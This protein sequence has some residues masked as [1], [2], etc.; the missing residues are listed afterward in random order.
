MFKDSKEIL[1]EE[2]ENKKPKA[3][4]A[5]IDAQLAKLG[6]D[7]KQGFLSNYEKHLSVTHTHH[8]K[9]LRDAH[10]LLATSGLTRAQQEKKLINLLKGFILT[11]LPKVQT[12]AENF[13]SGCH[14]S[15]K[16][17]RQSQPVKLSR[18]LSQQDLLLTG[19]DDEMEIA[20]KKQFVRKRSLGLG[21]KLSIPLR[22][23]VSYHFANEAVLRLESFQ[24]KFSQVCSEFLESWIHEMLKVLDANKKASESIDSLSLLVEEQEKYLKKYLSLSA[25]FLENLLKEDVSK[26]SVNKIDSQ[27]KSEAPRLKS[28]E[29]HA[30]AHSE[31]WKQK[32]GLLGGKSLLGLHLDALKKNLEAEIDSIVKQTNDQLFSAEEKELEKAHELLT[33]LESLFQHGMYLEASQLSIGLSINVRYDELQL[34]ESFLKFKEISRKPPSLIR[35]L[36]SEHQ[37]VPL[38]A[39]YLCDY[40]VET[41]LS[42]PLQNVL[43]QFPSR[44]SSALLPV[45]TALQKIGGKVS[46]EQQDVL[47]AEALDNL[48]KNAKSALLASSEELQA[49]KVQF[50][51]KVQD[52]IN[53]LEEKLEVD[54]LIGEAE[55]IS[56]ADENE[57]QKSGFSRFFKNWKLF[58]A[59]L[60]Y[61]LKNQISRRKEELQYAEFKAQ[62]AKDESLHSK[63]RNLFEAVSPNQKALD[64]L[65]FYYQ[66]LFVGKHAPREGLYKNREREM[67][68]AQVALSRIE[69][70][71]GGA[72]LAIGEAYSGTSFFCDM[73]LRKMGDKNI[74]R[75][76]APPGGSTKRENLFRILG[77][78]LSH[79]VAGIEII[80]QAPTGSVFLFN[81][82][83]LWWARHENGWEVIDTICEIIEHYSREYTFIMN[84]NSQAYSVLKTRSNFANAF[85]ETITMSPFTLSTFEAALAERRHTDG[86]KVEIDHQDEA[87]LS[88]SKKRSILED[89]LEVSQGNIGIAFHFWLGQLTEAS[90]ED[91]KMKSYQHQVLPPIDNPLWLIALTQFVLHKHLNAHKLALVLK[92]PQDEM[93]AL[94]SNLQR[95]ALIEEVT[96]SGYQISPYMQPFVMKRLREF[97]LI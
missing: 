36:N 25:N 51:Q 58:T 40:L 68:K 78:Q 31:E 21:S 49:L 76:D 32:I 14:A 2:I 35:L 88:I 10:E 54:V 87:T 33:K 17:I 42:N 39:S 93:Q 60:F 92:K 5:E 15:L 64:R 97:R 82:I 84:M 85:I 80:E 41:N 4:G 70:G 46:S 65:P 81:H 69:S 6:Q 16:T 24:E 48:L 63:L 94:I 62:N 73:L 47:S 90:E 59:N 53:N 11:E 61:A 18:P 91:L 22:S 79:S 89:I 34:N 52:I 37:E 12:Y 8:K 28:L 57:E 67:R 13:I 55:K 20:A 43:F 44:C 29:A 77:H 26:I 50:Q 19:N 38:D 83:E 3:P 30:Q 45:S 96:G 72:I 95:A 27:Y 56:A 75:I 86:L 71:T 66:Q 7:L 23:L 1:S 74:Y 9:L